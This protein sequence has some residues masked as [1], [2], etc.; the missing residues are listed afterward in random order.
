MFMTKEATNSNVYAQGGSDRIGFRNCR[1]ISDAD[2]VGYFFEHNRRNSQV[3]MRQ[4]FFYSSL[5]KIVC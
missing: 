2:C 5:S 3:K 4:L 1:K